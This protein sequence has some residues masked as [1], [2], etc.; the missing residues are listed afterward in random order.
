[1]Y[2]SLAKVLGNF[3]L[4]IVLIVPFV[5]LTFGSVGLVGF[6]SFINGQKAVNDVAS[7]LREQ[8][9]DRVQ[10]YLNTYLATPHIINHIN[11]DAVRLGQLDL[12]NLPKL[13]QYLV[14][15]LQQFDSVSGIIYGSNRGEFIAASRHTGKISLLLSDR[16]DTSKISNYSLNSL[17]NRSKLIKT[18]RQPDARQRP[19]YKA[20]VKA[21]KPT[22]TPI[23]QLGDNSGFSINATQPI[24]AP[25]NNKLIGVFS[26]PLYLKK[27]QTFLNS[28]HVG[29]GEIFIVEPNGLLVASSSQENLF[30]ITPQ[31]QL[32]RLKATNSSNT[33]I[34]ATSRYLTKQFGSDFSKIKNSQKLNFR[35]N[36][37]HNFL[38]VV[39]YKFQYGLNL[40]IVVV[41]PE[42]DFMAQVEANTYITILLCLVTLIIATLIGIFTARWVTEP[43]LHLNTAAKSLA[44]GES[45]KTVDIN[46]SDEVGQLATS[47]NFMAAQLQASFA[48]LKE[49]ENRLNQFLEAL[50]VGVAVH[51]TTSK[52]TYLNQ[53]GKQLL[54]GDIYTESIEK[55]TEVYQIYRAGTDELYPTEELPAIR[56]LQGNSLQIEDMELH[57]NGQIIPLE[58]YATPIFDEIGNILYSIKVFNDIT[59]RRQVQN[60]LADYSHVLEAQVMQ[61][62][63]ELIK[64]NDQLKQEIAERQ[65]VEK[66]LIESEEK[67]QEI[68][69][70]VNQ[71]FFIRSATTDHYLYVSPAYEKLWGLSCESL[72]QNPNSWMKAVHPDDLGIVTNSLKKQLQVDFVQREFRIIHADGSM[73]WIIT[74]VSAIRNLNGELLRLIGVA[75]DITERKLVEQSLQQSIQREQEKAAELS[76]I[77][78][79]LKNTQ[80]QLIQAEKMSG[81]G[82]MVAGIAHEINNPASFIQGNLLPA[83]G[84]FQSLV[85]LLKLYQQ[86][87]PH[88]TPEIAGLSEE[89]DLEFLLEDWSKLLASMQI[90]A[91]RIREIVLSL[92]NFS[93]LDE[94][95]L[96]SVD[97]H[98]GIDN[99]ILILQHRLKATGKMP[100]I[101]LIKDYGR[102]PNVICYAGQ[103]NQVFMNLL[104]NAIDALETKPE[105]RLIT[106]KTSIISELQ[107]PA[108]KISIS[109]NGAG[110]S[111][112][113]IQKIFDPFFTTK[114]VG[115][116]TGLGL[117]ISY[118]I[119]VKTHGGKIHCNSSPGKGTEFVVEIPVSPN[120]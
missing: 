116:G 117:S 34:S 93:R 107:P 69:Q 87:Y 91:E 31:K 90:G 30:T 56:A 5:L 46:R 83:E 37:E 65:Q 104:S 12:Q 109:D 81:L 16:F 48:A 29:S 67:F 78:S 27:I 38:Q 43:I 45:T 70:T 17:G 96:K 71:F 4:R 6:L 95:Q 99:T 59:E 9:S 57:Q 3:R 19:W 26:A 8:I 50:P 11:A 54:N 1:M 68:A 49:S 53:K 61:R 89:I 110:M 24:Y 72:Y 105:P 75:K 108:L 114:P 111:E 41:V 62:T 21:G 98:E 84:Y 63:T 39:P 115:S 28:L 120:N 86:T 101:Q 52:L 44:Q 79:E 55:I 25:V 113:I 82:Q 92:R 102:L 97:I 51:D 33:L 10:Q 66:A 13:E 80:V 47:F 64:I 60:I 2:Y 73:R 74:E 106:I 36:G 40:I 20:A 85:A 58:V 94:K 112:S 88:Q 32:N 42:S 7:Q 100:E 15:Q 22:W 76:Q 35:A 14:L 103:L 119:V 118:Q 23:F 18:F 77:L